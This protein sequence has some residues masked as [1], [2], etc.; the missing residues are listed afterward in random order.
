[1][2]MDVEYVKLN[3]FHPASYN[4]RQ[5][6]DDEA[7][8]LERNLKRFGLVDPIIVNLGNNRIVGGHQRY[9]VLSRINP[10]KEFCLLR[11]GDVGWVFDD[12][13]L[14]VEDEDFEKALNISLNKISGE[15][16]LDKLDLLLGD[17]VDSDFDTSLTGFKPHELELYGDDGEEEIVFNPDLFDMNKVYPPLKPLCCPSCKYEFYE[18]D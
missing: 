14:S 9:Y 8:K 17:L 1:M 11:L 5:I 3:Q 2:L 12:T 18:E 10:D 7:L 4:P 6:S 13:D 15:W 16:N